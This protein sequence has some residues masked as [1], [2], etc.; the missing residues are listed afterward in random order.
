MADQYYKAGDQGTA[1]KIYAQILA[2]DPHHAESLFMVGIISFNLQRFDIAENFLK[3]AAEIKSPLAAMSL[4]ALGDVQRSIGKMGEAIDSYNKAL[5][6]KPDFTEVLAN[7]SSIYLNQNNLDECL[8]FSKKALA[9]KPDYHIALYNVGTVHELRGRFAEA[10]AAYR[11]TITAKPDL[12]LA[13]AGLGRMLKKAG[14]QA[15][16]IESLKESIALRPT[17]EAYAH[18]GEALQD[19]DNNPEA[20]EYYKKALQLSPENTEY[21][22][23]IGGLYSRMQQ[24][25]EASNYYRRVLD[26]EPDNPATLNNMASSL[27]AFS[28]M[29]GAIA[30]Y[31][32]SLQARPGHA[33]TY[34][35]LLLSM[36]YSSSVSAEE[37]SATAMEFGRVIADPLRKDYVFNNDKN[38]QKR[39]KIGYVSP[40]FKSH[41]VNFFF[42]PLLNAHNRNDFEVYGYASVESKDYVTARLEKS[43]DHWRDIFPMD[44]DAVADLIHRDGI[45]I[46]IDL[47]G[48]TGSNRLLVF[49]RKPAPVQVTWLGYPGTTGVK[50]IDY[51]I[52]DPYTAPPGV[53]EDLSAEKLWRMPDIFCCYAPGDRIVDVIDH[54]PFEDN[55]HITFGCFNNFSKV[56]DPVLAVWAQI[57]NRVPGSKLLLEIASLEQFRTELE[58]RLRAIGFDLERVILEPRLPNTQFVMY[59]RIDIALDPFPC[60]G[61]TTSMDC[62]WMGVPMVSLAGD[63]FV[64]RMGVCFLTNA[65]LSQLVADTTDEYIEKAVALATDSDGLRMMRHNL[66]GRV[67]ASPLM[68]QKLFVQNMEAAYR[69]MWE[70]WCAQS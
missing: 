8:R 24:Y 65:G 25:R 21:L 49:A 67:Q 52:V 36:V 13:H 18:I 60:N 61:G 9:L 34:T 56:T 6:L 30:Y 46:L 44:D 37:L 53:G 45:D 14:L 68:D 42:E 47:A 63:S 54:P 28:Q 58:G 55:G 48:H 3:S 4:K 27:K 26:K 62:L 11:S 31:R 40:D 29:D 51:R 22:N 12:A 10:E 20:L 7:L 1:G 41:S 66:R 59:N 2:Q 33:K 57:L 69:K 19:A 15:E 32:K 35:N 5:A 43:F 50:A 38:P 39:L 17:A 16:A 64:S 70:I 23:N